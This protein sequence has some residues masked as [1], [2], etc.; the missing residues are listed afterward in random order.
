MPALFVGTSIDSS[1]GDSLGLSATSVS[2]WLLLASSL[3]SIVPKARSI[4]LLC[5]RCRLDFCPKFDSSWKDRDVSCDK[6]RVASGL[7]RDSLSDETW[8]IAVEG[9]SFTCSGVLFVAI[10]SSLANSR[11]EV[12]QC[13]RLCVNLAASTVYLRLFLLSASA[14][15]ALCVSFILRRG[16][17]IEHSWLFFRLQQPCLSDSNGHGITQS[18]RHASD[19]FYFRTPP[20][21][22][23]WYRDETMTKREPGKKTLIQRSMRKEHAHVMWIVALRG[24]G[25]MG[26]CFQRSHVAGKT[27]R[28]FARDLLRTSL[29]LF[30]SSARRRNRHA[31]GSGIPA[32]LGW[33]SFCSCVDAYRQAREYQKCWGH[34]YLTKH[35]CRLFM[36]L[37]MRDNSKFKYA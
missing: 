16:L 25:G 4:P 33:R 27:R 13:F 7:V 24:R 11:S 17:K 36:I 3:S 19:A 15:C 8:E 14:R 31:C 29:R 23:T 21:S 10:E 12:S 28:A 34:F 2:L 5:R 6:G 35:C 26:G 22:R 32:E 20:A 37:M 30:E 18:M 9:I 1:G